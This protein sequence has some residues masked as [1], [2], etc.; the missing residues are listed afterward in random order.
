MNPDKHRKEWNSMRLIMQV[1]EINY[2][3][4]VDY[5]TDFLEFYPVTK[6]EFN[7]YKYNPN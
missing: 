2:C 5:E 7:T 1:T 3:I 4:F 6:D